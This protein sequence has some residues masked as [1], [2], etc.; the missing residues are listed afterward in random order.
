MEESESDEQVYLCD[1]EIQYESDFISEEEI[2]HFCDECLEEIFDVLEELKEETDFSV[3]NMKIN[4]L[5]E[6]LGKMF[7]LL[8]HELY[9]GGI[10]RVFFN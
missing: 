5:K 7:N 2:D 1:D 9:A 6:T 10:E 3:I 4:C 8:C